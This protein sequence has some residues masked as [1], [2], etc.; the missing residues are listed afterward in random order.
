MDVCLITGCVS[1]RACYAQ[2]GTDVSRS[3]RVSCYALATPCP[4]ALRG[5]LRYWPT[6]CP[7]LTCCTVLREG[8]TAVLY[9]AMTAASYS[10]PYQSP[11]IPQALTIFTPPH[12]FFFIPS[13]FKERYSDSRSA[14]FFVV[15]VLLGIVANL[16]KAI[17]ARLE[18]HWLRDTL[19]KQ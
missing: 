4:F 12:F 1:Q 19:L 5:K 18:Q 2:S 11:T 14:G 8:S 10:L 15:I 9:G 16:V 13:F 7:V 3:A 6:R 17:R